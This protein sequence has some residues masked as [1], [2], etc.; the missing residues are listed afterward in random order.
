MLKRIGMMLLFISAVGCRGVHEKMTA[1]INN[2]LDSYNES[3]AAG[4]KLQA[5]ERLRRCANSGPD[6]KSALL[7]K[8]VYEKKQLKINK[9]KKSS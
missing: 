6:K 3:L 1:H 7:Y 8:K 2:T 9:E 5:S 4:N